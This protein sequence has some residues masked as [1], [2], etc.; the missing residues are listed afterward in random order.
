MLVVKDG[1]TVRVMHPN[2]TWT[3]FGSVAEV[4]RHHGIA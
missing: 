2:N 3:A 4:C 1:R